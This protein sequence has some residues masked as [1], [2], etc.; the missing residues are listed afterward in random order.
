M[1]ISTK[2]TTTNLP[3]PAQSPAA[4]SIPRYPDSHFLWGA[5]GEFSANPF[6]LQLS[7]ISAQ[8]Q[9]SET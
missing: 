4:Q 3:Q 5:L 9:L 7:S 8:T 6:E 1:S 2:Q